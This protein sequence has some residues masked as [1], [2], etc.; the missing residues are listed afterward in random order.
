MHSVT[1][2][3]APKYLDDYKTKHWDK[4]S[5]QYVWE[6]CCKDQARLMRDLAS[7]FGAPRRHS[8]RERGELDHR[9]GICGYCEQ[10]CMARKGSARSNTVDH[11]FPR[12]GFNEKMF[13]WANMIY[14][15]KRCNDAKNDARV[16]DALKEDAKSYVNPRA[17][18]AGKYFSYSV[19]RKVLRMIPN[20]ELKE[21]QEREKA[22]RT[23]LDFGLNNVETSRARNLPLLRKNY[24]DQLRKVMKR[25]NSK[26]ARSLTKEYAQVNRE[27][28]SAVLWAYNYYYFE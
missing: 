19:D 8:H 26:T 24:L 23:I 12:N 18:D 9:E 17:A 5:K 13:D 25:S 1:P 2:K 11:F 21:R 3:V 28:S 22:E 16:E 15:C 6:L 7:Q 10:P 4:V 20:M 27:F 14:A